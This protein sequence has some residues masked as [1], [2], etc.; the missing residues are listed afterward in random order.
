MSL[1]EPLTASDPNFSGLPGW[2]RS[3][4]E[5]SLRV[6]AETGLPRQSDEEWRYSQLAETIGKRHFHE[7]DA[8]ISVEL[9]AQTVEQYRL[10]NAYCLTFVDGRL[11]S[12]LSVRFP[13]DED[14]I[15]LSMKDALLKCPEL[16][17]KSFNSVADSHNHGFLSFTSA[18]GHDGVFV[19]LPEGGFLSSP[20]QLSLIHI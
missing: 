4:R 20:L 18:Y 11:S 3:L 2:M 8:G 16:V 12:S 14:I 7:V 9:D 1:L 19:Y 13:V 6:L 17:E 10:K 15:I 5:D